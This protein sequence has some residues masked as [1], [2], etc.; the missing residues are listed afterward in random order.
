MKSVKALVVLAP[1]QALAI[2]QGQG[3]IHHW[4]IGI[5]SGPTSQGRCR[6]CGAEREF[7]NS[8]VTPDFKERRYQGDY[9]E[10]QAARAD[11]GWTGGWIVA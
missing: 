4:L 6:N 3:C 8:F 11:T 1:E 7:Q 9:F 5:A 2:G 10:Q